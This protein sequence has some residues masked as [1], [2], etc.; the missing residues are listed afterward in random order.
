MEKQQPLISVIVPINNVERYVRKCLDSLKG[1]TLRE[2]EVICIDDGSTDKSGKI[3]DEYES[4]DWPIFRVIHTENK[5]LSIARN[6][7]IDESQADW[8]MFVDS[9]DWVDKDFCRIPYESA[10][11]ENA[12]LVI[13]GFCDVKK[14]KRGKTRG[15]GIRN[16]IID[17]FET[18]ENG[19][20]AAW[21]KL[22]RR[23][24]FRGIRYPENRVFEDVATTHKL[25]HKA[26]TIVSKRECLYFHLSRK[27][28]ISNT[29][30][31]LYKKDL[32]VSYLE[33]Y[34]HLNS[35]GFRIDAESMCSV[36]IG[37]LARTQ[38]YQDELSYEAMEILDSIQSPPRYLPLKQKAA[39][40]AWKR[41]KKLFKLLSIVTGK[42]KI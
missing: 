1:Q 27:N 34:N 29:D 42:L 25:V 30:S 33:R 41:N 6:R 7:G 4:Q 23:E 24:L 12:D 19:T 37:Y 10:I 38:L 13:V 5:G 11:R 18:H 35:Y 26:K 9:D 22:Y 40:I 14:G 17:E 16:G 31:S 2:I 8:L 15:I 20:V 32:L 3:A 39:F 28:S 21:N 36:A